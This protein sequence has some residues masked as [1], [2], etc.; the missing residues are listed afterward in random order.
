MNKRAFLQLLQKR[1]TG[2]LSAREKSLLLQVLDRLQRREWS[3]DLDTEEAAEI[4]QRIKDR[5]DRRIQASPKRNYFLRPLQ[6]AASVALLIG[7]VFLVYQVLQ[8]PT[9]VVWEE[10]STNERQKATIT[11]PDGSLAYLNTNTSLRFPR[12]FEPGQRLVE[13]DGEAFFE[14]VADKAAVFEVQSQ[15]VRTKVLG[16][17]FNVKA[18]RESAVKVAVQ[19][20]SVAV[21]QQGMEKET[22]VNLQPNQMATVFPDRREIRVEA[23]DPEGFLAWKAQ[24]VSFD[25]ATFDEVI[26]RLAAIYN[27]SI[28]I[29]G[30][31]LDRC[32][33]KATY[34]N[35]NL[36]AVLHGL[37]NL[38]DFDIKK[39]GERKVTLYFNR[40]ID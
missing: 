4:Q 37:K 7:L 3:W 23:V 9:E 28:E 26:H 22:R 30:E 6:L 18:H 1:D 8:T 19:H 25:L 2:R 15:G 39:T 11:L 32:Q 38:V 31:G 21:Y 13:L 12:K 40:C 27:Y 5:I 36:Y 14:V 29:E 20:G 10:R 24:S 33:I 17:S 16:T 35:G 34:T